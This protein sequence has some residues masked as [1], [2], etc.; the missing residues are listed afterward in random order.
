MGKVAQ[1]RKL[2]LLAAFLVLAWPADALAQGLVWPGAGA[3]HRSLAGASTAAGVDALGALYWNP[4]ALS[5]LRD[6]Q[7]VIGGEAVIGDTH[8]GST[9][10][11]GAFSSSGTATTLSGLTRSDSGVGLASGVGVAYRP[12]DSPLTF[13]VG[14]ITL[15][16][17]S[18]NFP[19]NPG[20]PVLAPVGPFN[21]FVLGPQ[22]ASMTVVGL[23]PSASYQISDRLAIGASPMIDVAVVSFDPAFFGPPDDSNGDG[24]FTFPTGSHSRP[25]WGGGFRAGLSYRV[26]EYLIAGFSFISPQ[27]FETWRFNARTETGEPF[28]FRTQFTLPMILSAGIAYAGIDRLLLLADLR[29]FDYRTSQLLGEPV[30]EGGAGWD[31]IWAIA[32]G[33]RYQLT[34]Q[35]SL[36]AGYLF[37]ENPVPVDP[38]PTDLALFNTMLP[39]LTK[40]TLSVGAY[41]QMNESI[42]MSLAYIHGFKNSITGDI[43]PLVG[44]STTLDTEYD[45]FAFGLH[46]KFGGP[47]CKEI[48]VSQITHGG[49]A[50]VE[51]GSPAGALPAGR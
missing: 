5:W 26:T 12:D 31:S 27:W 23:M 15:A 43:F 33:G 4:A 34:E 35:L 38:V 9:I 41:Y 1:V 21:R 32:L 22:A 30:R 20:N 44:T 18:V 8:L 10:P 7:V 6:S 28:Q 11:A 36:Q 42:G 40:H 14:L 47:R 46:I 2:L 37:N 17:G 39:A 45:S 49:G 25:F 16:G 50:A 13:G 19:G 51:T 48:C 29:W 3:N 24:L